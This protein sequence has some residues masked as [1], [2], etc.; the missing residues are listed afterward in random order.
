MNRMRYDAV[1]LG[2]IELERGDAAVR[3]IVQQLT[4]KVVLSNVRPK[5]GTAPWVE[6]TVLTA[7]GRRV[8]VIGLVSQDFSGKPEAFDQAGFTVEDPFTAVP[9]VVPGLRSKTDLVIAL[10]HLK[11]ADLDRLVET[12]GQGID[13]VIA[14]FS[15]ASNVNQ[16]DTAVTTILRPGQRGEYLGFAHLGAKD[17]ATG[18]AQAKIETTML[19]VAKFREDAAMASQLATLKSEIDADNRKAQLERELKVSEGL[20]LGQDRYLGN[21]TC[22]RCHS[23]E[24]AWWEKNPH[25]HAFAT[26][27]K[28]G[29]QNDASCLPCHVTGTG[30][31]G[32][33]GVTGTTADMRN[34]QCE[35]CHGMGTRHDWTGQTAST[36]TEASCKTCHVP[37]WSPKWDYATYLAKLGHGNGTA[38]K[39]G[40]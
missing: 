35:S 5:T 32:G 29:K 23:A 3:D 34:V 21:E 36:V 18:R 28:Q 19:E 22:A 26:L 20:V 10:A 24:I 4:A 13:L 8:G 9:R 15:P 11:P 12:D 38:A 30:A 40:N 31:A 14:G 25:A 37:E 16:P 1:S 33:F 27:E 17:P 2:Q 6:S 7:G 39:T